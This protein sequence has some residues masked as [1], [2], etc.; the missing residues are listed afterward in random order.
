MT[1]INVPPRDF[2]VGD[3]VVCFLSGKISSVSYGGARPILINFDSGIETYTK[4]GKR[5]PESAN[6]CLFHADENVK[7][8]V[9][10]LVY[11]YKVTFKYGNEY[12]VSKGRHK[13]VEDF[14]S[15]NS[16]LLYSDIELF[17]PSKRLVENE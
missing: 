14:N 11:N 7:V 10:E 5:E 17:L 8:T 6:R 12:F 16:K 13:S 15:E 2:K 9:T 1:D 3:E 4:Q